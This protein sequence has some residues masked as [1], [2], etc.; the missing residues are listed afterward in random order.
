MLFLSMENRACTAVIVAR[1]SVM[2]A[3]QCWPHE[4]Q[5]GFKFGIAFGFGDIR[6]QE[7]A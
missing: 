7:K 5:L 6:H 2:L 3:S 1:S 4:L